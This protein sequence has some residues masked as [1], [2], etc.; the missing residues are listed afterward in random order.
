V[1]PRRPTFFRIEDAPA[2]RVVD[3]TVR[4][5]DAAKGFGFVSLPE[6][7]AFLPMAAL[8]RAGL[9][10][11]REGATIRCEIGRGA[12]GPLVMQV[13]RVENAGATP[14]SRPIDGVVKWFAAEKGY[15]FIAPED[16]GRDVFVH[17]TVL[18]RSGI[19]ALVA[20][21]RVRLE[22]VVGRRGPE[23]ERIRLL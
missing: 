1:Y 18:R 4:W 19:D 5:F 20:G 10:D 9:A 2:G 14:P 15:G 13:L 12:K 17:A 16:G 11:V 8:R 23:A 3:A 7:D 22:V 21:Q 6:G